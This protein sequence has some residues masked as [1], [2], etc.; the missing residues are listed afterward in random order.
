[1][2]LLRKASPKTKCSHIQECDQ[3]IDSN[4]FPL[5]LG[6][7]KDWNFNDCFKYSDNEGNAD[8]AVES[9]TPKQWSEKS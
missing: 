5:C 1:M 7:V 9:K 2:N 3:V 8:S 6:E 4:G